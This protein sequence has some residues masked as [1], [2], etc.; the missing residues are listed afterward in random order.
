MNARPWFKGVQRA[1]P[2]LMNCQVL[3]NLRVL[4]AQQ[5]SSL[6]AD[7]NPPTLDRLLPDLGRCLRYLHGPHPVATNRAGPPIYWLPGRRAVGKARR[8]APTAPL[9][10]SEPRRQ[11]ARVELH[12]EPH[13]YYPGQRWYGHTIQGKY[14]QETDAIAVG[15]RAT[16]NGQ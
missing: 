1:A 6:T 7:H 3:L 9:D 2:A 13:L 14:I 16:Q 15:D 8:G 10:S 11:G 12:Q 4:T 5:L